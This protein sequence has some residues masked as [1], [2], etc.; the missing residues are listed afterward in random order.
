MYY[1]NAYLEGV[2]ALLEIGGVQYKS[3]PYNYQPYR[4]GS[5]KDSYR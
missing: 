4:A 3:S 1:P 5:Y 2:P